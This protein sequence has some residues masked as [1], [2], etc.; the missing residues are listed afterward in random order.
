MRGS[1]LDASPV[2]NRL[3]SCV[4]CN[5]GSLFLSVTR[6]EPH[7]LCALPLSMAAV[8]ALTPFYLPNDAQEDTPSVAF[9]T[10]CSCRE[11]PAGAARGW[12]HTIYSIERA[13][14][15]EVFPAQ[16]DVSYSLCGRGG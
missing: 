3:V 14:V 2:C 6:W 12:L 15:W 7:S 4:I 10:H 5:L 1:F 13:D 9:S 11:V 16:T 8:A